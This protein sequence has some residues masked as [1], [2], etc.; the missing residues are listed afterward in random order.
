MTMKMT[1]SE[2]E[3]LVGASSFTPRNLPQEVITRQR[4]SWSPAI[5]QFVPNS[6]PSPTGS[7]AA[8]FR[9]ARTGATAPSALEEEFALIL[10]AFGLPKP[11]RQ[12]KFDPDR[13][14]RFDFAW[15]DQRVA[16]EIEGGIW[17]RGKSGHTSGA[18]ITR[19]AEKSNAAQLQGW[20]VL[21]FVESHLKDG[22]AIEWTR[23]A[24]GITWKH[25]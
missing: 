24:L 20:L 15:V 5:P 4:E 18:G 6:L 12:F 9:S 11:E 22:S 10:R 17:S 2:Y 23:Q 16:V 13:N 1:L 21:R 7:K 19:D 3:R 8:H 14:W 25:Q